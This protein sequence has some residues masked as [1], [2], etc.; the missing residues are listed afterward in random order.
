MNLPLDIQAYNDKQSAE[1]RNICETL[2]QTINIFPGWTEAKLWH[3][4]PV[5]FIEGNPIVGYDKLKSCVR[6]LFRSGQSF[7]EDI[8]TAE[9]SFQAA[10]IRYTQSDHIDIKSLARLLQKATLIQRDY[11]NIVKRK[12]KLEKLT[13]F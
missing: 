11:K 1:E 6:L 8:L 9:G 5:W 12:G 7:D 10:D 13:N 2:S 3:G 4:H